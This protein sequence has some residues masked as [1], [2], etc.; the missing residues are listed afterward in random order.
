MIVLSM[1]VTQDFD[2]LIIISSKNFDRLVD[3]ARGNFD[4]LV[5]SPQNF[6][7]LVDILGGLTR[8]KSHDKIH[9]VTKFT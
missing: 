2:R 4:R 9:R 6:D 5:D 8:Q 7:R 3:S 1:I